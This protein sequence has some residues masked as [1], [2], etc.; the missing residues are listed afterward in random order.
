MRTRINLSS[1]RKCGCVYAHAFSDVCNGC[2]KVEQQSMD[3]LAAYL[4]LRPGAHINDVIKEKQIP[5]SLMLKF[6]RTGQVK[7]RDLNVFYPCRLCDATIDKGEM[8][9]SCSEK[10]N[11][12]IAQLKESSV[13]WYEPYKSTSIEV[14]GIYDD[15]RKYS[16]TYAH[17]LYSSSFLRTNRERRSRRSIIDIKS[18]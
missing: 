1:C 15:E 9:L 18:K 7:R 2:L 12:Q 4:R 11:K 5:E 14:S 3:D 10:L 16:E 13:Q 17:K 8:C 6:I